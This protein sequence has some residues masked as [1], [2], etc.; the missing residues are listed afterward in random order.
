MKR[1]D[2]VRAGAGIFVTATLLDDAV[3][4]SAENVVS[5]RPRLGCGFRS[6]QLQP[7]DVERL[8]LIEIE[9]FLS[10]TFAD[11]LERALPELLKALDTFRGPVLL[12]GPFIDLNPGTAESLIREATFKQFQQALR[13][14]ASVRAREIIYLSSYI[15]IINLSCEHRMLDKAPSLLESNQSFTE[16]SR[17]PSSR[18]LGSLPRAGRISR[19]LL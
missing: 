18:S 17:V 14:A 9:D 3:S 7:A 10:P 16:N 6:D 5:I 13:F 2:F 19:V 11:H 12:S 8:P 15:P 4:L 1:R